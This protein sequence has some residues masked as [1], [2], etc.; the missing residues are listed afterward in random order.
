MRRAQFLMAGVLVT[1]ALVALLPAA[2]VAQ[3]GGEEAADLQ[4]ISVCCAQEIVVIG[5]ALPRN[6]ISGQEVV[7]DRDQLRT[8][9]SGRVEDALR[10]VA[11]LQ[12]FRRSDARSAHPTSQGMTL[13]GLGGNAASRTVVLLDGV[14]V[15]D[16][17]GGWVNWPSISAQR[18]GSVR[19]TRG[20]SGL[21]G[22]PGGVAGS[23][24]LFS[25]NDPDDH[26][27]F[28]GGLA[29]GSRNSVS[30]DVLASATLG[31]GSAMLAA[32]YER[33]DGFY[34]TPR[35]QRGK[36][37][38]RAPYEQANLLARGVIDLDDA[39]RLQAVFSGFYDARNRGTAYSDSRST[40]A[41]ASVRLVNEG[42]LPWSAMLYGQLR[43]MRSGFASVSADRNS[44]NATLDQYRVPATGWGGAFEIRP[45]K[46]LTLGADG[47]FTS[48][49]SRERYSFVAGA[50]TRL[51]KA[52]GRAATVGAYAALRQ[53]VGDKVTLLAS[54]RLDHWRL[55]DGMLEEQFFGGPSLTD[56]H[57]PR[58]SGW[59][60]SA[61]GAVRLRLTEGL[62]L[63]GAAYSNWRLPTLNE[64]Y[65]PYRV[66]TDAIAANPALDPERVRGVEAGLEFAPER[67][68][69]LSATL[70]ANRLDGAIANVSLA[71]G[72]GTFPG[73]GFVAAG[74]TYKQ[75]RN[76]DAIVSRGAELDA[77]LAL[78]SRWSLG[79][80]YAYTD[81]SVRASG[82]SAPLDR[83]RPA[84]V[85]KHSGALRLGLKGENVDAMLAARYIGAQFED[86]QNR[87]RLAPALTLDAMVGARIS[88][89]FRVELRGENLGNRTV[90]ATRSRTGIIERA[91]PR[92]LWL[93]LRYAVE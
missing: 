91:L 85:P 80:A 43:Q 5:G 68:I 19:V 34:P 1:G 51:R 88:E 41:D 26:P 77:S 70:Y 46:A 86:D 14:P 6:D 37:D 28:A 12:Q 65:R 49:A 44:V 59:E 20:G 60:P 16:P 54:A 17:F 66:G 36:A 62:T 82:A 2:A 8:T 83:L 27:A 89:R 75:R 11:G 56:S 78:G 48:G 39:T 73:V 23:I 13:R 7:L 25:E 3:E 18:L 30:A 4:P 45:L 50:P 81:A 87:I 64:L 31:S 32:G 69:R 61:S 42:R 22:G 35:H 67:G 71:E 57:F 76:L 10:D 72:P 53:D 92:T 74:G 55:S 84:Q 29:Y 9:A 24:E 47:R 40:G 52:G 21:T 79:A 93:G 58:R 15:T 33:S 38:Q 90:E 63:R